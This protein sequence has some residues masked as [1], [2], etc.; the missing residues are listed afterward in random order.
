M[1][2]SKQYP[3]IQRS[4]REGMIF[5]PDAIREIEKETEGGIET[6]YRYTLLRVPD[7]GQQVE[8][9]ELFKTENYAELRRLK[10]GRWEE[11]LEL[12]QEQGFDAWKASCD[13]VKVKLPKAN[14]K[15]A[16]EYLTGN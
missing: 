14:S 8:D 2:E 11:Q 6:F 5:F 15:T 7:T 9:Y 1:T 13:A 10:Y 3:K 16:M 4:K 12:M